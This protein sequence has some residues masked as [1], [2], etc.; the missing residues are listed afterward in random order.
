MRMKQILAFLRAYR[1]ECVAIAD[2][3]IVMMLELVGSRLVA[4]YLGTSIYVWTA[5]IGVI[6]GALAIGNWYGG[7][8]ADRGPSTQKLVVIILVA[9]VVLLAEM[10]MQA[11]IISV[12]AALSSDLRLSAFIISILVFAPPAALMGFISPYLAKLRLTSLADAG[13][14]VGRLYA[15]GTAGSIFGTF[16]AGY[17]LIGTVGSQTLGWALVIALVLSSFIVQ[18]RGL[19]APR[20]AIIGMTLFVAALA[21]SVTMQ[22]GFAVM[23]DGDTSYARYLVLTE[24]SGN[25]DH[26]FLLTDS[27]GIQSGVDLTQPY[28][29]LFPY[30]ER[31]MEAA[32][33]LP[34]EPQRILMIGGGTF[35]V[36]TVLHHTYPSAQIDVIEID[37]GLTE[38]AEKYFGYKQSDKVHIINQDGRYFLN[39][40][41][42]RADLP[43][44]DLIYMDA[45]SS[46]TPPFQLTTQEAAKRL[47]SVL[48]PDGLLVVNMVA[49]PAGSDAA[50]A[51]ASNATYRSVFAG[52]KWYLAGQ[53]QPLD[54]RQNTIMLI[55]KKDSLVKE[56]DA[57]LKTWQELP[58]AP[59]SGTKPVILTDDHA[60][61]ERLTANY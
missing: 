1:F 54:V 8:L 25:K 42:A 55:S 34:T 36:P 38:L 43:K 7:R 12:V 14:S 29:P 16:L 21:Q 39:Q 27:Q 33:A 5:I 3:M 48:T 11:R 4:P 35:T 59:G 9:A 28:V 13:Q 20:L 10:T 45:Y 53:Q 22:R 32:A 6:L 24:P 46:L 49:T 30:A 52:H 60:P 37:P 51:D 18:R 19:L 23:Y 58:S 50:F 61:V 31:F 2:G 15:A 47:A 44:Y 56:V 57:K 17:W 40:R 41:A 26:R